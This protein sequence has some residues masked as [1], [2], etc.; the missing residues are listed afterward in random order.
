MHA[1]VFIIQA[2]LYSILYGN[3]FVVISQPMKM[4]SGAGIVLRLYEAYG[5]H[6]D[7]KVASKL[8]VKFYQRYEDELLCILQCIS[9]AS[10]CVYPTHTI[11]SCNCQ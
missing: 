7:V 9:K 1:R 6:A 2:T 5:S 3:V 8:P 11:I 10:P 4:N